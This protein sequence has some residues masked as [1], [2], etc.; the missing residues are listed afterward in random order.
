MEE[1]EAG[2]RPRVLPPS[3]AKTGAIIEGGGRPVVAVHPCIPCSEPLRRVELLISDA[4]TGGSPW[5]AGENCLTYVVVAP[6]LRVVVA[7]RA[8]CAHCTLSARRRTEP[9]CDPPSFESRPSSRVGR[10]LHVS[11]SSTTHAH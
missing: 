4:F 3:A 2:S 10:F 1:R 5:T 8:M 7:S 6:D 9:P 11:L